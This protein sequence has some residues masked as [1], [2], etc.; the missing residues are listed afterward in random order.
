MNKSII[1]ILIGIMIGLSSVFVVYSSSNLKTYVTKTLNMP[2]MSVRCTYHLEN[3][4]DAMQKSATY[5]DE[6]NNPTQ[7]H[8]YMTI[9]QSYLVDAKVSCKSSDGKKRY[10]ETKD[11]YKLL[12]GTF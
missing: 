4:E 5:F 9:A 2:I 11:L 6:F 3:T 8:M 10:E 1:A 12:K 7:A